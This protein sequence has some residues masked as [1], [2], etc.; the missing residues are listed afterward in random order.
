MNAEPAGLSDQI[1]I[2]VVGRPASGKSTI[3]ARIAE[4]LGLP[5]IAKDA[6]KEIL[7]D[8]LGHA[9]TAWSEMLGTASFALLDYVIDVQL[10]AGASFIVDAAYNAAFE[11]AKFQAWQDEYGFTAVQVHCT[12]SDDELVRRFTKRWQ[13]GDRHPG[14]VDGERA[15]GFR[16][17]LGDGRAEVLDL[18]GPVIR[19]DT[20]AAGAVDETLARL[21][22]FAPDPLRVR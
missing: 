11:N 20:Q 10:R 22:R 19:C 5:I 18:R 6:L 16:A 12:A 3:S 4:Q 2:L 13:D 9:D 8:T 21:R 17:S 15:D 1:V 7:F 14:H